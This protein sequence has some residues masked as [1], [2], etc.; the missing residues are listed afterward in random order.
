MLTSD[1]VR[2]R[3]RGATVAPIR[4]D[5]TDAALVEL[6]SRI[7]AT[8]SA[9]VDA[10]AR[11]GEVM[12]EVED[13]VRDGDA[14]LGRGLARIAQDR[15]ET[16]TAAVE[17][18]VALRLDLFRR[19]ASRGPLARTA[20]FGR[21]TAS[22]VVAE[23][24]AERGIDPA[25]I[26]EDLYADLPTER[27]LVSYDV[28]DP[29]WLVSRYDVALIQALLLSATALT[30]RLVRP[31]MPRVRQ[32]M[33]WV[34]FHQLLHT[35]KLEDGEL[36]L[37]LDGPMSL[38]GPSTRYGAS[39]AQ[40]F[41]ALLLQDGEW[42]L[43]ATVS[44]TKAR[45]AKQLVVRSSDGYRSHYPDHGAYTTRTQQ[46]FA[47]RFAERPR[48]W[49]LAENLLPLT[50]STGD[51]VFPDFVISRGDERVYLEIV[52]YW[53]PELLERRVRAMAE[54]PALRLVVAVSRKLLGAAGGELPDH[55]AFV[56]F[57]DVLSVEKVLRVID[58]GE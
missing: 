42:T 30:V 2:A 45:H 53:R 26:T 8:F 10:R 4:P 39:L 54:D 37:V 57:T 27:R 34:K 23:V 41:P 18:P 25:R 50:L 56:P 36:E 9:A 3:V 38:F 12:A 1:L 52:G 40:F 32:L 48:E 46:H 35:A 58:G 43:D 47:A 19:A 28:A 17:D 21:P 11:L 49:G 55:P 15:C 14:K 7:H 51:L 44:W 13:L 6:A 29:A 22:D 5:R 20:G 31:A 33:R 24:A 16:E